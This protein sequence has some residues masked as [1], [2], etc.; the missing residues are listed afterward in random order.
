MKYFK[1]AVKCGHVGINNYIVKEFPIIAE[2]KKEAARI[3][4]FKGRV[5]HNQKYAI[6]SVE[7][8]TADEYQRLLKQH[9]EDP[10]MNCNNVQEQNRTCVGI[11]NEILREPDPVEYVKKTHAR[12]RL[13][14]EQEDREWRRYK[15][16][17][18]E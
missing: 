7:E 18:D 5:K 13:I 15:H 8:L 2:T 1:V 11:E 9:K 10:Y 16:Y 6:K 17:I 12:Q 4:R 3:A 14:A